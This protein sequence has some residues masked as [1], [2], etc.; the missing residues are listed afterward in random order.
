MAT[1]GASMVTLLTDN[2]AGAGAPPTFGF[3]IDFQKDLEDTEEQVLVRLPI[4]EDV[5]PKNDI[6]SNFKFTMQLRVKSTVSE[7]RLKVLT[8]ETVRIINTYGI[9]NIDRQ[10]AK[11]GENTSDRKRQVFSYDVWVWL[12]EFWSTGG[13]AYGSPGAGD[14]VFPADVDVTGKLTVHGDDVDDYI[15]FDTT[16]DQPILKRIGGRYVFVETDDANYTGFQLNDDG[17]NYVMLRYNKGAH[18]FELFSPQKHVITG[19]VIELTAAGETITTT[20]IADLLMFGSA[21][22]VWVPCALLIENTV[23]KWKYGSAWSLTNIDGIN[24]SLAFNVTQPM[25]KG[26]LKLYIKGVQVIVS[27]ADA[28][29]FVDRIRVTGLTFD[30]TDTFGDVTTDRTSP[31]KYTSAFTTQDCSGFDEVHVLIEVDVDAADELDIRG[32][33]VHCY[34]AA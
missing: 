28:A 1:L 30:A 6:Y 8:D 12:E 15:E 27:D 22:A 3:L 17:T 2:W 18:Q 34:Y 26:G 31:N 21:N 19:S 20:Q 14:V 23:G 25:V 11:R 13:T 24:A 4:H 7:E 9:T 10:F 32:V 29:A 16:S 5:D 33:E